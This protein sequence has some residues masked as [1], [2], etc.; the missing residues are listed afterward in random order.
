MNNFIYTTLKKHPKSD[1]K[2][3]MNKR[4]HVWRINK[5]EEPVEVGYSDVNTASYVGDRGTAKEIINTEYDLDE[6]DIN[7]MWLQDY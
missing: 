7:L 5:D 1:I 2:R 4:I 6:K 3:G